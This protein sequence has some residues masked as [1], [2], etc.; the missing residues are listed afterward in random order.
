M[1]LAL[2]AGIIGLFGYVGYNLSSHYSSKKKFYYCLLNF[3]NTLKIQINFL[4]QNLENVLKSQKSG[5]KE[6]LQLV[7]NF[8]ELLLKQK[9]LKQELF[10]GISI[11]SNEEKDV[12]YNFFKSL[13]RLDMENQIIAIDNFLNIIDGYYQNSKTESSKY[14][15][16][17]IK[18]GIIFGAFLS[19]I[20][21]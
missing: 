16:L 20:I 21:I 17:Y 8:K 12:I 15:G 14:G 5:S 2:C 10:V 7:N 6:F 19:L 4:E 9:F 3:V 1:K 13:G 18:L 11:L